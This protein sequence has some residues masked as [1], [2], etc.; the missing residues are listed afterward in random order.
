M[1][2][3]DGAGSRLTSA[4]AGGGATGVSLAQ[5]VLACW[6]LGL[7]NL[8][9]KRLARELMALRNSPSTPLLHRHRPAR[10]G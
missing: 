2:G 5:T 8:S 10:K 6:A 1:P 7:R 4:P 9:T 3:N